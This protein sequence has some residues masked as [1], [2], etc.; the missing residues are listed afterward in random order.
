MSLDI[1]F[2]SQAPSLPSGGGVGGLGET[3]APD[4]STGTGTFAVPLDLPHG[5]NDSRPRLALHYDSGGGNGPLGVGWS[6][7]LPRLLRSTMVGRPRYDD[8][9]TVVLEGAGPLVRA[10]D[11]SLHPEVDAGDWRLVADGDAFLATDRAGT[12]HRLGADPSSRIPGLG[13][14]TWAWLLTESEDNL[15]E[16]TTYH[17]RPAGAQRYLES[18][19]WGPF[20]VHFLWEPRPDVIRWGRGGFLLETAERCA[21]VEL[22][23][24]AE[25]SPLVRR[26]D[27]DYTQAVGNGASLLS[28][29]TLTGFAADGTSLTAP[30]L[31]LGYAADAPVTLRRLDPVDARSAPPGLTGSGRVELVDWTGTGTADVIAFEAD[32]TARV[33]PNEGGRLGRPVAAGAV[34]ALGG[35]LSR[36]GLVDVDGDG[37]ADLVRADVPL[38]RYQTRTAEGFGRDPHPRR[39]PRGRPG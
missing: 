11:G 23:L 12:R 8:S 7:P 2:A 29:V 33:W 18:I 5:P 16:R 13:S 15:G 22:H 38:A 32:G 1:G 35:P 3:F 25:A 21:G 17:W 31:S 9:D 19:A 37:V 28:A 34:P 24:P 27:L 6:L 30:P 36:S 10:A 14:G 39:G 4:L 26:W 20:E